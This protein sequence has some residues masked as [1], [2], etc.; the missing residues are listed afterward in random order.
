MSEYDLN[1]KV[2]LITGGASGIGFETATAAQARGAS[3]ALVD[4]DSGQASEA[5]ASIGERAIGIGA[6]VA[7][8]GEIES[9]VAGAV[10]HFGR[11]D[12][13]IANAGITPRKT[14]ARAIGSDEWERIVEV[15]LLGVWRTIR[16]GIEQVIANRGQFV[17]ISSSYAHANGIFNSSYAT[18]KAAVEAL[19]RALRAELAPHGAS[20][21]VAYFG[22]VKTGL[23]GDVFDNP[24][25]D[26]FRREMVPGVLTRP[27]EVEQAA[28]ALVDGI[29]RRSARVVEPPV[30]R[31]PLFARGLLGPITDRR[32]DRDRRVGRFV[33][34]IEALE[35]EGRPEPDP[36]PLRRGSGPFGADY[37]LL[38]KT[39][40]ITGG[41]RGIGFEIGRQAYGRGASVAL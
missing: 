27:I 11:V 18:S 3:I 23:I 30:W 40:L 9:A 7:V 14:T 37:D 22:F 13:V 35:G 26:R 2:V 15:N 29:E 6:D 25:A 17:L 28:G 12:V 20:A 19:G 36:G 32:L 5:A 31:P 39:V 38:G 24:V 4:L 33:K 1:G 10:D 8:A 21:T 16:A 41:A 34:E